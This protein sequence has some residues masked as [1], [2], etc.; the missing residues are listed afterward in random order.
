[1]HY[2]TN[3]LGEYL[4]LMREKLWCAH[5]RIVLVKC[6]IVNAPEKD[7]RA[8]RSKRRDK[9]KNRHEYISQNYSWNKIFFIFP[10][11]LTSNIEGK[12]IFPIW[13]ISELFYCIS[14]SV[15]FHGSFY[16]KAVS[17]SFFFCDL[18]TVCNGSRLGKRNRRV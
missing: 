18:L 10:V 8:Y 5:L 17:F 13:D 1:M 2:C 3:C 6:D 4:S 12:N 14:K 16:M 15:S 11:E 9:K 7:R